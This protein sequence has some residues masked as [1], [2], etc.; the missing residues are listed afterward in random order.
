MSS[1]P[2]D[3][4]VF[5]SDFNEWEDSRVAIN[6]CEPAPMSD[7]VLEAGVQYLKISR[8]MLGIVEEEQ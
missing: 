5:V 1:I 8:E 6:Y 2:K 3:K 4:L 7:D